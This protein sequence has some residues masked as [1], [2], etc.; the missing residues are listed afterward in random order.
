MVRFNRLF[1]LAGLLWPLWLGAQ[2]QPDLARILERLDRL[3]R[4]N[5][6]LSEEVRSLRARLDSTGESKTGP[7]P[8]GETVPGAGTANAATGVPA[9]VEEK[10]DIQGKRIDE[11]AQTKSTRLNSRHRCISS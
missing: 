4:D 1:G 9:T 6:A 5:R 3:E 2:T 11:Q 10:L 8:D 7:A